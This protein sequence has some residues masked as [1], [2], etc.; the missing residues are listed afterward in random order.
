MTSSGPHRLDPATRE[1]AALEQRSRRVARA[2]LGGAVAVV[3]GIGYLASELGLDRRELLEFAEVSV[4]MTL[5]FGV[6]G[7]LAGLLIAVLRRR[8]QR[9]AA[10]D[11][12]EPRVGGVHAP[13]AA[14]AERSEG[15]GAGRTRADDQ[16]TG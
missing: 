14:G 4:L 15:S 12:G 6:P 11:A 5:T 10:S 13:D 1:R 8:Q 9:A 3:V 2:L 16:S 7:V